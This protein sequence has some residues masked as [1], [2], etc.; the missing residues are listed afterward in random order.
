MAGRAEAASAHRAVESNRRADKHRGTTHRR[1]DD[2]VGE[3]GDLKTNV[4]TM[5]ADVDDSKQITD[6]VKEW[7]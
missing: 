3:V 6:E 5:K 4:E 7:K 1:V 2:L